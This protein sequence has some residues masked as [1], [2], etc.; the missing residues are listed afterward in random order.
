MADDTFTL[1]AP[2]LICFPVLTDEQM[3]EA[4]KRYNEAATRGSVDQ[5]APGW[6]VSLILDPRHPDIASMNAVMNQLVAANF[7]PYEFPR[8]SGTFS[9]PDQAN[10]PFKN[11]TRMADAR[12]KKSGTD[13]RDYLRGK[14]VFVSRSKFPPSLGGIVGDRMIDFI[15]P[16][17]AANASKFFYGAEALI[18]VRFAWYKATPLV[19]AGGVNAYLNMVMVT[20]QGSPIGKQRASSSDVFKGYAGSAVNVDPTRQKEPWE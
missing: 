1:T 17:R 15:G 13:D 4:V 2:G 9:T 11:G 12:L 14:V 10:K 3:A 19:P 7:E 8:D 18:Q 6:E 16:A 5:R 20:G